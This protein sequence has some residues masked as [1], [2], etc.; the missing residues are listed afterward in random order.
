[1]ATGFAFGAEEVKRASRYHQPLYLALSADTALAAGLLAALAWS[2]AGDRL[3]SVADSLPAVAA[4]AASAA[5]VVT[6][7]SVVRTPLA[8]WS[9]WWRERRWGFSTQSAAGW[10]ADRGKGLAV[11][12]V[13]VAGA[14]AAAVAL[15]RAFPGWW[16]LPAGVA[17]GLAVLFLSFVAPVVLEPLFNRFRPLEDE[18]LATDLRRLSEHAGVPVR[19]VLVADASRRTTKVNAYVSGLGST[20]RVVLFDTLLQ[21]ADPGAVRVVV[22][23]EL[24]HRRERHVAKLTLLAMAGAAAAVALLWAV[25]GTRIADPQT[26]PEAL[27]LLM[28]LE[29]AG[30]PAGSWLSRRFERAADRRSLDLTEDPAA[31]ARAHAELARRN[32]ADLEPPRLAYVL[33]FS[34]PT[35]PERLA[36]GR[37]WEDARA[38]VGSAG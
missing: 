11:S 31:F 29:V 12:I 16:A 13:L 10:L 38:A 28:A 24:G 2:S 7:S 8:L 37:A 6:C 22:A 14:W 27:L 4:A 5:L 19:D 30:L 1:M 18:E 9:G 26:L 23:H 33:L 35:P 20:R 34:H 36:A 25:L 3:F 21:A 15:A 32:L 17:L